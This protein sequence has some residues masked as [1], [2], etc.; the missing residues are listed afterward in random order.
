MADKE[1]DLTNEICPQAIVTFMSTINSLQKG[2]ELIAEAK[3]PATRDTIP[4]LCERAGFTLLE[5][6]E[7]GDTIRFRVRK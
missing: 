5:M 4:K 7:E 6:S 2:E 1:L 3:D